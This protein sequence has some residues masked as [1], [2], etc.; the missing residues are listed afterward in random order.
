MT[1]FEKGRGGGGEKVGKGW[2]GKG[3][4]NIG[5]RLNHVP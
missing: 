2:G 3:V 1:E 5:G 4:G